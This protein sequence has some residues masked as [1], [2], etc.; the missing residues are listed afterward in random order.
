MEIPKKSRNSVLSQN[1]CT[2]LDTRLNQ[3]TF[4]P[5]YPS[6]PKSPQLS[7]IPGDNPTPKP[8]IAAHPD[9]FGGSLFGS[10]AR[11]RGG[12]R[13]RIERH[14]DKRGDT[15]GNGRKCAGTETFPGGT[16]GLVE[17]DV[18]AGRV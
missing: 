15:A 18:C 13:D 17:V 2:Y 10:K 3:K 8:Q 4:K 5:L 7:L 12:R 9:L 14:V 16:A 6:I 1:Y 11:E